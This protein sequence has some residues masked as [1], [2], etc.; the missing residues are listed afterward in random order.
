MIVGAC[1]IGM[2]AVNGTAWGA[3]TEPETPAGEGMTESSPWVGGVVEG[4]RMSPAGAKIV[5]LRVGHTPQECA[6]S[7][8]RSRGPRASTWPGW[9]TRALC[10]LRCPKA[11]WHIRSSDRRLVPPLSSLILTSRG[12]SFCFGLA[13]SS[14]VAVMVGI[15]SSD[16]RLARAASFCLPVGSFSAVTEWNE[17]E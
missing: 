7:M 15:R 6:A 11:L 13:S 1:C 14:V 9:A 3:R 8:G 4:C 2:A 12:G 16:R 10:G 5:A 17:M